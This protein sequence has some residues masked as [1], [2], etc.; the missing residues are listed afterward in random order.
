[1]VLRCAAELGNLR[2]VQ[3]GELRVL[4]LMFDAHGWTSRAGL[5]RFVLR[6]PDTL[7]NHNNPMF[8]QE[9]IVFLGKDKTPALRLA[10]K[11][12]GDNSLHSV[13][14]REGNLIVTE[15]SGAERAALAI[16]GARYPEYLRELLA[17]RCALLHT[18]NMFIHRQYHDR[19]GHASS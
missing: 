1:M 6:T 2:V 8:G 5:T 3:P 18:Q 12:G 9:P 15:L 4:Q 11:I 13:V 17:L 7:R 10:T 16:G 19:T 14:W